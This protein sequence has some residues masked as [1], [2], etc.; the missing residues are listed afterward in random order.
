RN[1][2][3]DEPA[4]R[5]Q[6]IT[7][8]CTPF[9]QFRFALAQKETDKV[10]EGLRQRGIRDVALVLIEL[11]GGEKATRRNEL[12]VQLVDDRRLADSGI[13]GD[14]DQLGDAAVDDA[15]EG[16]EQHFDVASPPVELLGNQEPVGRV[17]FADREVVDPAV[18]FPF[19]QAAAEVALAAAPGLIPV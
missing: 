9:A 8:G 16:G 13:A 2:I 4:V 6:R 12:L 19:S 11:A 14:E 10:L 7:K 5:T 3:H 17:A 18:R 15:I 1:E